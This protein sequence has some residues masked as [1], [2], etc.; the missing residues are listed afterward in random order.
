[1]L[2]LVISYRIREAVN[3]NIMSIDVDKCAEQKFEEE[4]FR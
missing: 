3:E 1:M 4:N 2:P